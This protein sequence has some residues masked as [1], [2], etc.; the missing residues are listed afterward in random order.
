MAYLTRLVME[1]D[2][3]L[4]EAVSRT[5][6]RARDRQAAMMMPGT[7]ETMPGLAAP[8]MGAEAG[9]GGGEPSLEALLGQ[10]G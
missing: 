7:P 1:Q 5:D 2:V 10:L 3:T 6:Q 8:G 9:V 4:Y